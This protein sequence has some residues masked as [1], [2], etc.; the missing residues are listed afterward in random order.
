[1]VVITQN[2]FTNLQNEILGL[3]SGSGTFSNLSF[4]SASGAVLN[5]QVLNFGSAT[6]GNLE[7][8]NLAVNNGV[9][10]GGQL[11]VGYVGQ[12]IFGLANT[13]VFEILA[14]DVN[15]GTSLPSTVGITGALKVNGTST[16]GAAS[17]SSLNVS[18]SS[19]LGTLTGLNVVGASVLTGTLNVSGTTT[20]AAVTATTVGATTLNVSGTT[21]S[22][23]VT[24][25]TGNFTNLAIS[26]AITVPT[27]NATTVNANNVIAGTGV[28]TS[29]GFTNASGT[30]A[31]FSNLALD[32]GF[33]VAQEAYFGYSG[34][35]IIGLDGTG[36]LTVLAGNIDLGTDLPV[37]MGVTG[38]MNVSGNATFG[39]TVTAQNLLVQS[40]MSVSTGAAMMGQ[41][42]FLTSNTVTV[43]HTSIAANDYIFTSFVTTSSPGFISYTIV[44][45]TSI[46]F[47]STSGTDAST[48]NYFIVRQQA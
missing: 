31:A 5:T 19:T 17:A 45:N 35:T 27:V 16:L 18:G 30:N 33:S 40:R 36:A 13:G 22:G 28:F 7:V 43:P 48:I 46:T 10:I 4:V 11:N 34:V 15:I 8:Q 41:A 29:L 39:S 32:G 3:T 44:P 14:G 42:T 1:M 9:A 38:T 21:T 23:T 20:L 37:Q 26:S 2:P 24:A 12:R 25:T 47:N 6:G